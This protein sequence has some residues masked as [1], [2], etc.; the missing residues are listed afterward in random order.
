MPRLLSRPLSAFIIGCLA[1]ASGC[2][3]FGT[4]E[5]QLAFREAAYQVPQGY[6]AVAADGDVISTDADDWRTAPVYA[7]RFYVEIPPSPNPVTADESMSM[8]VFVD[9]GVIGGL[10]LYRVNA[11]GDLQRVERVPGA[12]RT[13][14][15]T[16]VLDGGELIDAETGLVRLVILDGR[17]EVVT[18]GDVQVTG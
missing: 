5:E 1:L 6:T 17:E 18:Y 9:G 8:T 7:G 11:L 14:L 10:S 2:D 12:T 3:A 15:Y 13:G 4:S 16:L